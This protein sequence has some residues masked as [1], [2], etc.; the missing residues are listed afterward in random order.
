M[1]AKV[2]EWRLDRFDLPSD[3]LGTAAAV[4][5]TQALRHA[6]TAGDAVSSAL[7]RLHPGAERGSPSWPGIR[8]AM[9]GLG[10][11]AAREYW[12]ILEAAFRSRLF[13]QRLVDC[14]EAQAEWLAEWARVVRTEAA[15]VLE[16]VLRS[17]DD[18]ADGLRRQEA[19]RHTLDALLKKGGV[20]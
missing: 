17:S 5:V 14:E 8:A 16:R 6:E 11:R 15:E 18:T 3:V 7:L 12:G 2:F 20:A 4:P 13:D 9:A 19:A 1:K 10:R